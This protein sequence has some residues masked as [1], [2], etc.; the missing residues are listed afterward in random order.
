MKLDM[1]RRERA[2]RTIRRGIYSKMQLAEHASSRIVWDAAITVRH[3]PMPLCGIGSAIIPTGSAPP[4]ESN[5]VEESCDSA[6]GIADQAESIMVIQCAA[7]KRGDAGQLRVENDVSVEFVAD[8]QAPPTDACCIRARP[9]DLSDSGPSC[10]KFYSSIIRYLITTLP[11]RSAQFQRNLG[12]LLGAVSEAGD[13]TT[14]HS[15]FL[16]KP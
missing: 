8:P 15:Q 14:L 5:H 10:G 16:H 2:F 4:L 9:D 13:R 12:V 11:E 6:A 1:S 3:R 7:G